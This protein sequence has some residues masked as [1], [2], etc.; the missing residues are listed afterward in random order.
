[1]IEN[2]KIV[3][4]L[5]LGTV[6]FGLKYGISNEQGQV[7]VDEVGRILECAKASGVGVLDTA[8]AYCNSEKILGNFDLSSFHVVTKMM[9]NGHLEESLNNLGVQRVDALLFHRPDEVDDTSWKCFQEYKEQG[10]VKKIGVSVYSPETLRALVERYPI[11]IVQ[12]PLNL[13]DQRFLPLVPLLI[14]RGIEIHVRSIFLQG[15]LLM[16]LQK[17]PSYFAPIRD[18]LESIPEPRMGY[19]MHFIKQQSVHYAVI[20]VTSVAELAEGAHCF[21]S[22]CRGVADYGALSVADEAFINPSL[23]NFNHE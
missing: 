22:L 14:Q 19:A 6:Q 11:D 2:E 18:K 17:V 9:K 23:W 7:T 10:L 3:P 21:S 20:G 16:D 4:R 12:M 13:L 1:M 8:Q 15:L 5:A